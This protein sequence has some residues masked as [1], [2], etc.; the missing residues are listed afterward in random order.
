MLILPSVGATVSRIQ[1]NE[2]ATRARISFS[3]GSSTIVSTV[4]TPSKKSISK[5]TITPNGVSKKKMVV[6]K[7]STGMP[8]MFKT[9]KTQQGIIQV[10]TAATQKRMEILEAKKMEVI[11]RAKK[12][13]E[14]L[15]AKTVDSTSKLYDS[16]PEGTAVGQDGKPL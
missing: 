9:V 7:E 4:N 1:L 10:P 5:T 15:E 8:A 14:L 13:A 11:E 2:S 16:L 3:D 6:R 12:R